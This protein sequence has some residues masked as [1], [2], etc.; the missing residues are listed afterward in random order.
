M[1][2][3]RSCAPRQEPRYRAEP[4]YRAY[5]AALFEAD[6]GMIA[7]RVRQA[8]QLIASRAR[9]LS[10][11]RMALSEL[12]ALRTAQSALQALLF[13]RRFGDSEWVSRVSR[14]E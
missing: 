6:P 3:E 8:E 13:H 14:S 9:E 7:T 11:L 12:H 4:W 5:M 10:N 1:G 2:L